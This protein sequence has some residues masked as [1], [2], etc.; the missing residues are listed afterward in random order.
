MGEK[1]IGIIGGSGIYE[2]EDL[3]RVEKISIETPFGPPSDSLIVGYI[4]STKLVFL[5]RHGKTHTILPHEINYRANIF[6]M[7]LLSVDWI[8]S[9]SAVGSLREDIHPGDMVCVDQF[10]DRTWGRPSSFFGSGLAVHVSFG[11]PVSPI[12]HDALL[13][14]GQTAANQE[15][16]TCHQT[17]TYITMNGPQFSTRAESELY[18]SW[19][20]SVVGM[21]NMPE[22]KLARE[23]EIS[24]ATLALVTDY[25]CWHQTEDA[26]SVEAV[27]AV[28]QTNAKRAKSVVRAVVDIVPDEHRCIA[29]DALR[30]SIV[31]NPAT[32]DPSLQTK[33]RP[34]IGRY[35]S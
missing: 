22:A 17:G 12:L 18:R 6:A 5:S 4:G 15:G 28:L 31:T 1:I 14:A 24:Y 10:V 3:E 19:G 7:K 9:L 33:L 26:V 27:M 30:Y 32:I 16:F 20:M 25:D 8:V 35:L 34:L 13:S 23:A 29:A 11:D 21:T 2:M